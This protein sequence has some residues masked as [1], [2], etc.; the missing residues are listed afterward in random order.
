MLR[1]LMAGL[2]GVAITLTVFAAGVV[3]VDGHPDRYTVQRGDTLWTISARFLKKPWLWPEIWQVN[4]QVKNPHRIY[5]GDQLYLGIGSSGPYLGTDR[6]QPRV[7]GEVDGEAIAP[8]PLSALKPYLKNTRILGKDEVDRAPHVVGIEDNR[9]RGTTGQLVY[10]RGLDAQPGKTYAVLRP[11]GRYYDLPPRSEEQPREVLRHTYD[12]RDGRASLIWHH[13]PIENTL[14]GNVRFLGYELLEFGTLEVTR[15][16]NPSSTLVTNSDFEVKAGDLV[17]P[18][19][20]RPYDD[21]YLPHAPAR[22]PDNMRIIALSDAFNAV[23][24]YQ[25]V[26]LSRGTENGVENGQ[27]YSIYHDGD[28][29]RDRTDYPVGGARA[30]LHPGDSKIQLPPEFAGHVMIF[31]TFN[32]V[33]YG[34]IMDAL[35]P[36]TLGDFL[37]DPDRTP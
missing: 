9:L 23:G 10:V 15:T 26:A 27:V 19:E 33:S 16:G 22:V 37:Y 20:D 34:L 35:K 13:G 2:A 12:D 1:R 24:T 28:V 6:L 5:P 18:V 8:L 21:S 4:P 11:L 25:V 29:V 30:F 7:R 31:K 3:L 17:L 36:V 14:R 32:S